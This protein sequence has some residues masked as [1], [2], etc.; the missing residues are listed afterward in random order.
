MAHQFYAPMMELADKTDLKSVA[1]IGRA[2]SN[3]ARR[4]KFMALSFNGR[5]AGSQPVGDGSI[6]FR[7]SKFMALSSNG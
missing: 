5:T 6:P 4:T 7:A 3:P 2:G 1:P